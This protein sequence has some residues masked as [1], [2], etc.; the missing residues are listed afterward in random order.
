MISEHSQSWIYVVACRPVAR[1]R[2]AKNRRM[3]FSARSAK[4]QL[5]NNRGTVLPARSTRQQ[6]NYNNKRCFLRVRPEM[7]CKGQVGSCSQ[8]CRRLVWDY[9]Q[10]GSGVE[11]VGWWVSGWVRGLL[12]FSSCEPLLLEAGSWGTQVVRK[13]RLTG[14]SAIESSYRITA[15]E[16]WEFICSVVIVIFGVCNSVRLS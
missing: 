16:E 2:P 6:L 9:R 1:Q 12:Q 8:K 7:L 4:Q 11:W 15:R 5:D 14:T 3:V 10:A 13:P